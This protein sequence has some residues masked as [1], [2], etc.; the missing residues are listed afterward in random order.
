MSH[1]TTRDGIAWFEKH[2]LDRRRFLKVG[3]TATAATAALGSPLGVRGAALKQYSQ[4]L[5]H[6]P[7]NPKDSIY[8]RFMFYGSVGYAA[9]FRAAGAAFSKKYPNVSISYEPHP[10][11]W[12]TKLQVE[13]AGGD[14]PDLVFAADDQMF[15]FAVRGSLLDIAPFFKAAGLK[16]S[17]FW[18]SAIN[19][20]FLGDHLF[21]MPIDY[22]L[23]V[24]FYNKQLF[25]Q[26]HLAYPT[27]KWTWDDF[28]KAG[29]KLTIDRSGKRADEAGFQPEHIKQYAEDGTL[30]YWFD[31][32]LRSN[33]GE[34]ASPDLSKS[35]LNTP[36]A[37][38]TFQWIADVGAKYDVSISPKYATSLNFAMEQGNVAMH[39]DG[40]WQFSAY[41]H[42][43][44]TKWN[45]G[46]IDIVPFPKGAKGR[47]I[48]AE[49]SGMVIPA[50]I[51]QQ[52][53][54]WAW[55]FVKFMTTE[56]GQRLGFPF[57]VDTI[58]NSV[59]LAQQ[60]VPTY[61]L[62]KNHKIIMEL[63]PQAKLPFWCEAISDQELEN[64]LVNPPY[65]PA[66]ELYD[67]YKGRTTALK[68]LPSVSQK[69]QK[70][71]DQD[72]QLARKFGAKLH[73]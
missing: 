18:P 57:G 43:P 58:P 73:L 44:I 62:P 25:D 53:V 26:Q 9:F 15:S 59:K 14:P 31:T 20:Q 34:W 68:A 42:Y 32:V 47:S 30:P 50:G 64:I 56:S 22:G 23:H 3:A 27:D 12:V 65:S 5:A 33:G 7:L 40:T 38:K 28:L 46:N 52:N 35:L 6:Q 71:L 17:D 1:V 41:P 29:R 8:L 16:R 55:E 4:W 45:Q 48:G 54:K 60:L 37:I 36:V 10:K 2:I 66:P 51:K 69:V 61:R 39:F 19:P 13:I 21:A 70:Y 72:Q 63:L 11:D 24:M 49:A 67:L